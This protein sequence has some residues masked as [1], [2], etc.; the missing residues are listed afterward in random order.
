MTIEFN[1]TEETHRR[2]KLMAK[3]QDINV[4]HDA[5]LDDLAAAINAMSA[6]DKRA[7]APC[8]LLNRWR[9]KSWRRSSATTPPMATQEATH[10]SSKSRP[11]SSLLSWSGMPRARDIHWLFNWGYDMRRPKDF[12]ASQAA[13]DAHPVP[14]SAPEAAPGEPAGSAA[15]EPQLASPARPGP[16]QPG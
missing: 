1:V 14:A 15:G 5:T 8:R 4:L 2:M 9:G 16:D 10:W 13:P 11:A 6:S 12:S 7:F 3:D